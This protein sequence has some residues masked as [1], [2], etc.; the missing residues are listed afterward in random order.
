MPASA[1]SIAIYDAAVVLGATVTD[2]VR[3]FRRR[4]FRLSD[5]LDR[6]YRS[7]RYAGIEPRESRE[8][9]ERLCQELIERNTALLHPDED[10]A[11]VLFISPGELTVYAGSAG[12]APMM[13]TFC[14][15][16]FPL[17]FQVW[18]HLFIEGA[19]VVTPSIRQVPPVCVDPKIKCRSRMHWWLADQQSHQVDPQAISLCLDLQGNVTETSGSNFLIYRDNTL[20]SPRPDQILRGV[21]LLTVAEIAQEIGMGYEERDFQVYDVVNAEEAYLATT[22]YCLAPV[23]KINGSMI[24]DGKP[25][26]AFKSLLS[27]WSQRVDCDIERQILGEPD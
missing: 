4:P 27:Q 8:E 22:P 3:T 9:T 7:C 14:I 23:T 11:L 1:A 18:R 26:S 20:M 16:T 12:G 10:L 17:P 2:L 15:H 21:S 5:H 19:H 24:G 6:F 13:P 25:G